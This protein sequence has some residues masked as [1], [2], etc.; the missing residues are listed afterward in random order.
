MSTPTD[1][2]EFLEEL[3]GG[4]S[5]ISFCALVALRKLYAVY[6]VVIR[7]TAIVASELPTTVQTAVQSVPVSNSI[8]GVFGKGC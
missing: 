6:N 5:A 1:T 8:L 3:N 4:A 2:A 7:T